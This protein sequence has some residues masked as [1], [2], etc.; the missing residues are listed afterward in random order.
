M[1]AFC[2]SWAYFELLAAPDSKVTFADK[3]LGKI[4]KNAP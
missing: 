4:V 1:V 3:I 2:F